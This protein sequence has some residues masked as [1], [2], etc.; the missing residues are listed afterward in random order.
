MADAV[1]TD[2]FAGEA[3]LARASY[4][5]GERAG[6]DFRAAMRGTIAGALD[7]ASAVRNA[8]EQQPDYVDEFGSTIQAPSREAEQARLDAIRM[9][10]ARFAALRPSRNGLEAATALASTLAGGMTS[11]ESFVTRVPG[12]TSVAESAVTRAAGPIIG[13]IAGAGLTQAAVA[14]ASGAAVQVIEKQSGQREALDASEIGIHAALGLGMG[15]LL[16]GAIGEPLHALAGRRAAAEVAKAAEQAREQRLTSAAVRADGGVPD[17]VPELPSAQ[18]ADSRNMAALSSEDPALR[19][20]GDAVSAQPSKAPQTDEAVASA[21]ESG[22]QNEAADVKP[23]A[24]TGAAPSSDADRVTPESPAMDA[25][26]VVADPEA[27]ARAAADVPPDADGM[28]AR[29]IEKELFDALD[30]EQRGQ[31]QYSA[32]DQVPEKGGA[33]NQ[34]REIEVEARKVTKAMKEAGLRPGDVDQRTMMEAAEMLW[35]GDADDPLVALE[36]AMMSG[37]AGP[38]QRQQSQAVEGLLFSRKPGADGARAR[39]A[40]ALAARPETRQDRDRLADLLFRERAERPASTLAP[41]RTDPPADAAGAAPE[42]TPAFSEVRSPQASMRRLADDLDVWRSDQRPTMHFADAEYDSGAATAR[43]RNIANVDDFTHEVG[44]H[45]E[46]RVGPELTELVDHNLPNLAHLVPPETRALELRPGELQAEAFA[47][48]ANR[49]LLS[50]QAAR[51]ASPEFHDAFVAFMADKHPAILDA[52]LGFRNAYRAW[53]SAPSGAALR[54]TIVQPAAIRAASS[55][56]TG[57]PL[58]RGAMGEFFY[59]LRRTLFGKENALHDLA[60]AV[61]KREGA[62]VR[63]QD[64]PG[65]LLNRASSAAERSTEVDYTVGIGGRPHEATIGGR[66]IRFALKDVIDGFTT[67]PRTGLYDPARQE[68]ADSY[69]RSRRALDLIREYR[70]GKRQRRPDIGTEGDHS[71]EVAQIKAA[72]PEFQALAEMLSVIHGDSVRHDYANHLITAEQRDAM[73]LNK[74]YVPFQRDM[75]LNEAEVPGGG[76]GSGPG[77]GGMLGRDTVRRLEGSDRDILSPLSQVVRQ[78]HESNVRMRMNE[79][80]VGIRGMIDRLEGDGGKVGEILPL[81]RMKGQSVDVLD[82]LRQR[83]RELNLPKEDADRL[84]ATAQDFLAGQGSETTLFRSERVGPGDVGGR[85]LFGREFGEPFAVLIR[86]T[87]FGRDIYEAYNTVGRSAADMIT[88]V[89]ANLVQ[90]FRRGTTGNLTFAAKNSVVDALTRT[91]TDPRMGRTGTAIDYIPGIPF[92]TSG[93]AT[94]REFGAKVFDEA[95]E[96]SEQFTRLAFG[97]RGAHLFEGAAER[98]R[99]LLGREVD[100]PSLA[101]LERAMLG[102]E[103]LIGA[104]QYQTVANLARPAEDPLKALGTPN[105]TADRPFVSLVQAVYRGMRSDIESGVPLKASESFRLYRQLAEEKYG[106]DAPALGFRIG[107]DYVLDAAKMAVVDPLKTGLA[108]FRYLAEV[109]EPAGRFAAARGVLR[110]ELRA[111]GVSKAEFDAFLRGAPGVSDDARGNIL[112]AIYEAVTAANGT[113]DFQRSGTLALNSRLAVFLNANLQGL[114]AHGETVKALFTPAS[115]AVTPK[116]AAIAENRAYLAWQIGSVLVATAGY[117]A[118]KTRQGDERWQNE[119][120]WKRQ[121]SWIFP[122]SD[123]HNIEVPKPYEWKGIINAVEALTEYFGGRGSGS[124]AFRRFRDAFQDA[125]TPPNPFTM[126][127]VT[128]IPQAVRSNFDSF[129]KKPIIPERLAKNSPAMQYDQRTTEGAKI[130]SA[131]W[132][133]TFD[134]IGMGDTPERTRNELSQVLFSPMMADYVAKSMLG[135]AYAD[136]KGAAFD[137]MRDKPFDP[138]TSPILRAFISRSMAF[139]QARMDA[140]ENISR[141]GG[142]LAA[143]LADYNR[144]VAERPEAAQAQF[145]SLSADQQDY[146]ALMAPDRRGQGDGVKNIHPMN[147]LVALSKALLPVS[148]MVENGQVSPTDGKE[149]NKFTI[150]DSIQRQRIGDTLNR[151]HEMESRNALILSGDPAWQG[152]PYKTEE[153]AALYDKLNHLDKRVYKELANRYASE[154]VVRF[155]KLYDPETGDGVWPQAREKLRERGAKASLAGLTSRAM[156]GGFELHGRRVQKV[157][158]RGAPSFYDTGSVEVPPVRTPRVQ[159]GLSVP[160]DNPVPNPFN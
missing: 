154:K 19:P 16:H 88:T 68:L 30:R 76:G 100:E 106:H 29:N 89:A 67:D 1:E 13:R 20:G 126:G 136:V 61:S 158:P 156:G 18:A 117:T 96:R 12:L 81:T 60:A 121:R 26:A 93:L 27:A 62:P 37:E 127:P 125:L 80:V 113:A 110:Y 112:S 109:S 142:Q 146:V 22:L 135:G 65:V 63:S 118:M 91:L 97:E 147:R 87:Q 144:L 17:N 116:D 69:V 86:D 45:I 157:T 104:S 39:V 41:G 130:W 115:K 83:A 148:Q 15:A 102:R 9:D 53:E 43:L 58:Q 145:R 49:F 105:V 90:V 131:F 59:R 101:T 46:F 47:E 42:A 64:N 124:D 5:L 79:G 25:P 103:G 56:Q 31:R 52:M 141:H 99:A 55:R 73:L 132:N 10:L 70:E 82:A 122:I 72:H 159:R 44:H 21:P 120:E 107:S 134:A 153:V 7:T 36:H 24:D 51:A 151:I 40:A 38:G 78:L 84:V 54:A 34:T 150:S 50:D 85:V 23:I 119:P 28:A 137:P 111:S 143:A 75:R 6:L 155:S 114:S 2:P 8:R 74:T 77:R 149:R 57:N 94:L 11:P 3:E 66:L 98:G 14:G 123:E 71:T 33:D 32:H 152:V 128:D 35:R 133:R 4:G 138:S 92:V 139:G 160:R 48:F 95:F 140:S 108:A 129:R